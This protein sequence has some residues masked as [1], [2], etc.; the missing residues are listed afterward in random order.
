MVAFNELARPRTVIAGVSEDDPLTR[1]AAPLV[2]SLS[3][4]RINHQPLHERDL[5][6]VWQ[7][8]SDSRG[9]PI[10]VGGS[11]QQ[12]L[13]VIQFGGT[14]V[15]TWWPPGVANAVIT[16]DPTLDTVVAGEL[17]IAATCPQ[18]LRGLVEKTL[19]PLMKKRG[20]QRTEVRCAW[21][22]DS[23]VCEFIPLLVTSDGK[24]LAAIYSHP[25]IQEVWWLPADYQDSEVFDFAAW[26]SAALEAWHGQES[27]RF[28]GPPDWTRQ[29]AWMTREELQLMVAVEQARDD[30]EQ[31]KVELGKKIAAA[32][33][34]LAE[35]QVRHDHEERVL[36]TGQSD[37]LVGAV[38][39]MLARLGFDVEDV[40]KKRD[41]EDAATGITLPRPKLEDLR[42]SDPESS[43]IA[44]VE[45][46]GYSGGGKTRDFQKITRFVNIY[47]YHNGTLPDATWYVVNQFLDTPPDSRPQLLPSE[48]EDVDVFVE[49]ANGVVVDTRDLFALDRLVA[50]ADLTKEEA[51]CM[52]MEAQRRFSVTN[53]QPPAQSEETEPE[54]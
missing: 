17:H 36:L 45:V 26:I 6:I 40:D 35:A 1:A 30:L 54:A 14:P 33:E 34:A 29:K 48:S 12:H 25:E 31:Q 52:L 20:N 9:Y 32:E 41:A 28:P 47:A 13:R 42:V 10:K 7:T 43:W 23:K 21:G 46:K 19:I 5:V 51:R 38:H 49:D 39:A 18:P 2:G 53:P 8:P 22:T 27:E 50:A 3:C 16:P 4:E 11:G 44:L 15:S 24:A 37:E